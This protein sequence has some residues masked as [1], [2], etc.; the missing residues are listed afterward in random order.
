LYLQIAIYFERIYS[1]VFFLFE[2]ILYIF[3]SMFLVYPPGNIG[4]EIVGLFFMVILQYVKLN[5]ANT[6]NKTELK[7]YH[8]YTLLYSIPSAG[9][10]IYYFYFQVYILTFD[11]I[12][13]IIGMVFILLEVVFTF[14]PIFTLK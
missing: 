13:C 1:V 6:A 11:F 7:A 14:V 9:F 2:I 8:F 3:K 10:Y 4:T 12:L 5:N